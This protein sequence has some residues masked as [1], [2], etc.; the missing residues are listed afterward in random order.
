M[1]EIFDL[2]QKC[3]SAFLNILCL[4]K[5]STIHVIEVLHDEFEQWASYLG[6]FAHFSV[7]LDTRLMYSDS[8]RHL[9]IQLLQI[10]MR[11][12]ERGRFRS[13]FCELLRLNLLINSPF[14]SV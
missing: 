13:T 9:I 6:V 10:S 14:S 3:K 8:L 5:A 11:N 2:A 7:C 4:P 1:T 12:L